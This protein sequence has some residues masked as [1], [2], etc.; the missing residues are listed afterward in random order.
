M[1][2]PLR[3]SVWASVF[4]F[5]CSGA[6]KTVDQPL[7]PNP[8]AG[9]C[10]TRIESDGVAGSVRYVAGNPARAL[11]DED[12]DGS[13]DYEM[14][15]TTDAQGRV[16]VVEK[17]TPTG[18][19]LERV[20]TTWEGDRV[21]EE[22]GDVFD[23]RGYQRADGTPDWKIVRRYENGQLVEETI[24]QRDADMLPGIDGTPDFRVQWENRDGHPLAGTRYHGDRAV[25][26]VANVWQKGRLVETRTDFGADG[27]VDLVQT[28]E[29][30]DEGRL[31]RTHSSGP[32]GTR[33]LEHS[34]CD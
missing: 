16:T 2:Q 3:V 7:P 1:I 33:V 24:D 28:Y 4:A 29:Y 13:P 23:A 10:N 8:A 34:Y 25:A 5:G 27:D 26:A 22:L 18:D 11:W 20:V 12:G 17:A 21:V 15:T 6:P 32:E 19:V 31:I 30:D 9:V 14:R